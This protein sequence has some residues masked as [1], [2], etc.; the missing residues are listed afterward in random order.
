MVSFRLNWLSGPGEDFKIRKQVYDVDAHASDKHLTLWLKKKTS[1][2]L[3]CSGEQKFIHIINMW[4]HGEKSSFF[5]V[6]SIVILNSALD[7]RSGKKQKQKKK[8]V[9]TFYQKFFLKP[10][11]YRLRLFFLFSVLVVAEWFVTRIN[12]AELYD[13]TCKYVILLKVCNIYTNNIVTSM[14]YNSQSLL[15]NNSGILKKQKQKTL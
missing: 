10:E 15:S 6:A 11:T 14:Y 2:S 4:K 5:S 13:M 12:E 8:T 3:Y 1:L 7:P 9:L